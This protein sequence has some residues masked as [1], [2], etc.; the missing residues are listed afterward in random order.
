MNRIGM[1]IDV[2]HVSDSTFFQVLALTSK[3][4]IASHSSCRKF[5][6]GFERNMNDDMIRAMAANG[7][8]IQINFGSTFIDSASRN[9]FDA[10]RAALRQFLLESDAEWGDSASNTFLAQYDETHGGK[11]YSTVQRVADHIDHVVAL[12]GV[13]HVGFGSDFDGVGDSLPIGLKD[14][15]MYPNLIAEL[16]RRDYKPEDIRKMCGENLMRVWKAN[17]RKGN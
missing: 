3:P 11:P 4:V 1:M 15:S 7:G 6:P 12:A 2:S 8:V 16:L 5:V 10:R 9:G 14:V 17:E 13:D